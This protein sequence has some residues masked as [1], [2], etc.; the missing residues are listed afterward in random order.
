MTHDADIIGTIG[1]TYF[2]LWKE[3]YDK[4]RQCIEKQRLHFADKG[5]YSQIYS[6][7]SSHVQIWELDYK[8][9]WAPKKLMLSNCHAGEDSGESLGQEGDQTSQ[10]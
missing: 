7:S 3:H 8:G 6:F 1:K 10:S 2:A 4:P 5:L 9:G